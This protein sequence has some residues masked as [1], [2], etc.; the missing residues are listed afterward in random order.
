VISKVTNYNLEYAFIG[1]GEG[2]NMPIKF[3]L[4]DSTFEYSCALT[5]SLSIFQATTWTKSATKDG[6]I[7]LRIAV[8]PLNMNSSF[9]LAS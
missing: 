5:V 2:V 8:L 1:K 7:H 6:T 9:T 3:L 4:P